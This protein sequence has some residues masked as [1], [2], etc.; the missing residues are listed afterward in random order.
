MMRQ[1]EPKRSHH[2]QRSSPGLTGRPSTLRRLGFTINV[3]EYWIPAFAGMT[4]S[5]RRITMPC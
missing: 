4:T 5:L 3:L 1:I 2:N